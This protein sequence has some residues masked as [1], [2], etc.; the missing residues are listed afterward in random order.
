MI[1]RPGSKANLKGGD[2]HNSDNGKKTHKGGKTQCINFTITVIY[3]SPKKSLT[4]WSLSLRLKSFLRGCKMK[5]LIENVCYLSSK[6]YEGDL[7]GLPTID[8]ERVYNYDNSLRGVR[9]RYSIYDEMC[10]Q[11]LNFTKEMLESLSREELEEILE[12]K[13][14]EIIS[15]NFRGW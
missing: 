14:D 7:Y 4:M 15:S 12:R 3:S 5:N 10:V 6:A 8:V 2:A 11:R 1:W 13:R 9:L